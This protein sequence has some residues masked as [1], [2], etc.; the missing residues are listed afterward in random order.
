MSP[1]STSLLAKVRQLERERG[2]RL[3]HRGVVPPRLA[4]GGVRPCAHGRVHWR[5]SNELWRHHSRAPGVRRLLAI[6]HA[7]IPSGAMDRLERQPS[8]QSTPAKADTME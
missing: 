4:R 1:R 6:I 5:G 7:G 8:G 3:S 2:L